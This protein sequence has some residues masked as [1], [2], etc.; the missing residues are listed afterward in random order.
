[1]KRAHGYVAVSI[2]SAINSQ[3]ADRGNCGDTDSWPNFYRRAG[4]SNG[5]GIGRDHEYRGEPAPTPI[6][7]PGIVKAHRHRV[8]A[9]HDETQRT[10]L[11]SESRC[12]NVTRGAISRITQFSRRIAAKFRAREWLVSWRRKFALALL[13]YPR[14]H[15]GIMPAI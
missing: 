7:T 15:V 13:T 4:A 3:P 8:I 9:Y 14:V 2:S 10:A 12:S 1:M 6:E 5:R 11:C